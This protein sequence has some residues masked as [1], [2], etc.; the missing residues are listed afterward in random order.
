[1]GPA[2]QR[3]RVALS[4]RLNASFVA[5]VENQALGERSARPVPLRP[6]ICS[7]VEG[8]ACAVPLGPAQ[9]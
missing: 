6:D 4:S 7:S 1:M 8:A 3:P 5:Q 2:A 9:G